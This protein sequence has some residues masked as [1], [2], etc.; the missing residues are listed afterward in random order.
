MDKNAKSICYYK[1]AK[2]ICYYKNA[3]QNPPVLHKKPFLSTFK[4]KNP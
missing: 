1:N 2:S 4:N 3:F